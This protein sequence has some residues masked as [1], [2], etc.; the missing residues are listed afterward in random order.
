MSKTVK[1]DDAGHITS[2]R[3][4]LGDMDTDISIRDDDG[5]K[6]I[7]KVKWATEL[8]GDGK[9]DT[10]VVDEGADGKNPLPEYLY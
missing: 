8:D 5:N 1:T 3:Y 6:I 10:I 4:T 9:L 2:L 7:D